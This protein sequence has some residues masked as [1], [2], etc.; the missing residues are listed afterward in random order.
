M[1]VSQIHDSLT[2][3]FLQHRLV[4][5]YDAA[6]E[7]PEE[8][9]TFPA[10]GAVKVRV[11]GTD[12]GTKVQIARS[13]DA[14]FLVYV[15]G[16]RP[17]DRDNW[18]LDLLLQ[19]YEY[20]ADRA[21]QTLLAL[22][23]SQ[24]FRDL[25]EAHQAFFN[26][27]NRVEALRVTLTPTD[28]VRDVRLRMM[29]VLAGTAA[30]IDAMLLQFLQQSIK[31]ELTDPAESAFGIAGLT[32]S[33]WTEVERLFGYIDPHPSVRDFAV[34]LFRGANPLDSTASL[35]AHG[36]VF[37]QRWKDSKEYCKVYSTLA[38]QLEG[39][40]QIRESLGTVPDMARIG[41]N[42]TFEI[43]EK[44][45][46]HRIAQAFER[47]APAEELR[48]AI[49]QRRNSFWRT[50]HVAGYEAIEHATTL[51]ELLDGVELTAE[52]I[53]AGLQRY[54]QGW[55]RIDTAYRRCIYQ[56]RRYQQVQ[57][58][59]P[60]QTWVESHYV[61]DFLLPLAD[62]WSDLVR[63]LE[64]WSCDELAPQRRFF[65]TWVEP[66]RSRS[67]KVFVIVSDALRYEAAA[68][69]AERLNSANRWTAEVDAAFGSLPSFT[70]LGMASLLPGASMSLDAGGS[71]AVDGQ[72]ASGTDN[73]RG[74]LA[75]A[76]G[77]RATAIRS[78][79]FLE[80]NTK[81]D[82]REL[83]R[84]NDVIY[85]H[86]NTID[87]VGDKRDTEVHTTEAVVKAFDEIESIIRK[88]ANINGTNMLLTADHGFMF[89]QDQLDDGD[90]TALPQAEEW[91][92]R[93]RRFSLGRNVP[94]K[95]DVKLFSAAAL[96]VQ[97]D[98]TAA[99]PLGL[100]RFPL[101]GS[102]KLYVHGGVSLQEIV[103]PVVKIRKARADDTRMVDVELLGVPS[104][105]TTGRVSVTLVQRQPA[106]EK[107][108]PRTLRI[109]VF[110]RD[111]SSISEQRTQ[112]FDSKVEEAR[113]REQSVMLVLSSAADR[114]N[115]QDVEL[116]L[117]E[118]VQGTTQW[119][120]YRSLTLRLQ[121]PFTSDFDD[122]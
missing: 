106:I 23:L 81:I 6:A 33:F 10:A 36:K 86:H 92:M 75:N 87:H 30:E 98:W 54:V 48:T 39:D 4:F 14:K 73:R 101:Q 67:Q 15:Q 2:R 105:I 100:G 60:I 20:R 34:R 55:W 97:G 58:M 43:F 104:K 24:D 102:G 26:S 51:R 71:V 90:M 35:H 50:A 31:A 38:T 121:K 79:E 59:K 112:T 45:A 19:G 74:I 28:E 62:R 27:K 116:R 76:C 95:P 68:D 93:N 49:A 82:G 84:D 53:D 65:D 5:W 46:L 37:L 94:P 69:F 109:G 122:L 25:V 12:F 91:T 8:F 108:L 111:G 70:Q 66:F 88:V 64:K 118:M 13:P 78:D 61:N 42:D 40:L 57:L 22:D 44:A 9:D 120:T 113:L 99:F 115:N 17:A 107:M 7:W 77:G 16:A 32:A 21:S 29:A 96:G 1:P 72:S 3:V 110:G 103:I 89:Q 85:I 11:S 52:S 18:L 63:P 41:E 56:L 83:M 119:V 114:L 80:L 117:E 47:G